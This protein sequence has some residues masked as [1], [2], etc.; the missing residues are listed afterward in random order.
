MVAVRADFAFCVKS[1]YFP[2]KAGTTNLGVNGYQS[3]DITQGGH[4]CGTS[5]FPAML[6][7]KASSMTKHRIHRFPRDRATL[8]WCV[9]WTA[10]IELTCVYFRF[11]MGYASSVSTAETIGTLTYGIRIHHGYVGMLMF[12]IGLAL[13]DR[14][15]RIGR[16]V[17]ILGI[18]LLLSD[19][20]H[21]FLVLWPITGNHQFD[22]RYPT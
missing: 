8:V 14:W 16:A 2:A 5:C 22:W 4:H 9:A 10:V 19:L 20:I 12:P 7:E 18:G 11:G 3:I 21:H 1:G 17:F 13:H 15:P 6:R